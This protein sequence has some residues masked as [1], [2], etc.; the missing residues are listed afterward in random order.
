MQDMKLTECYISLSMKVKMWLE[1]GENYILRNLYA[2]P[3][4]IRVI[5]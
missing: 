5:K 4:I 3:N 2:S 1:P